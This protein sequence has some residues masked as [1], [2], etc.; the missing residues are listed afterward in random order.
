MGVDWETVRGS[1]DRRVVNR[2]RVTARSAMRAA[3]V[4]VEEFEVKL[5][6][7]KVRLEVVEAPFDGVVTELCVSLGIKMSSNGSIREIIYT[8]E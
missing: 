4:T 2:A 7:V 5:L 6:R 3:A 8:F 1:A